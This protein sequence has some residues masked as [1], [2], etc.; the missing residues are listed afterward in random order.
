MLQKLLTELVGTGWLVLGGCGTAVIAA[1]FPQLGI[2]FVGVSLAFG[3]TVL[4]IAYA[5]GHAT[6][7]RRSRSGSR[8]AAASAGLNSPLHRQVLGGIAGA[9]VLYL[10]ASGH[11]GF[12]TAAG[13]ASNGPLNLRTADR[14]L[15]VLGALGI[16]EGIVVVYIRAAA[17]H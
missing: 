1:A 7:I 10:I 6:S 13:C 2:G 4:T 8:P 14:Q 16:V 3:L 5:I 17:A 9:G 11:A 15:R 12:S